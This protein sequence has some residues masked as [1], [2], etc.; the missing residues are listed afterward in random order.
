VCFSFA[1][2]QTL[3][4]GDH[5]MGW[6]TSV[7]PA[8]DGDLN[9]YLDNLRRLV[10]RNEV[11]YRPTHGPAIIDPGPYVEALV[12]H[13]ESRERQIVEALADGPR[14]IASL[15]AELYVDV[16]EDLHKAAGASVYAHLL[17]L[18]RADRAIVEGEPGPKS[19]W[20]LR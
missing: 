6:S 8:P 9:D 4:S 7:I 18:Q 2:E 1:E 20:G 19:E 3:F 16:H 10:G 11:R 5:V 15:V 12:A 17:A 13:R 14:T